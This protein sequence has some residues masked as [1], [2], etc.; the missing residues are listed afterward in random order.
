MIQ[1]AAANVLDYGAVADWNGT[2]GT[3]NSAAFIAAFN[4][5]N[6]VY[7]PKGQYMISSTVTIQSQQGIKIFGAGADA[8]MIA[9]NGANDGVMFTIV[10]TRHSLWE[11]FQM[12]GSCKIIY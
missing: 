12:T 8:T 9:W 6:S 11:D 7:I 10:G 4:S 3:D 5:G 2:T 1:G